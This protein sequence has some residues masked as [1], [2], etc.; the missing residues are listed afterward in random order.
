MRDDAPELMQ[1][2]SALAFQALQIAN[3]MELMPRLRAAQRSGSNL[4]LARYWQSGWV[5]GQLDGLPAAWLHGAHADMVQPDLNVLLNAPAE[6]C[7]E[8]RASRDGALAPERYEGKLD[9]TRKVVDLYRDLWRGFAPLDSW[10]VIDALR[11]FADVVA[12]IVEATR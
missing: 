9:F 12:D 2:A 4:V 3:R 5:Y 6:A 7:M 1:H 10:R 11:P 8:R